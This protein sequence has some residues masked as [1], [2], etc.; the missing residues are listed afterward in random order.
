M[1][2]QPLHKVSVFGA[3]GTIGTAV[4][5]ALLSKGFSV[6]AIARPSSKSTFPSEVLVKKVDLSSKDGLRVA[7]EGQD[8]VVSCVGTETVMVQPILIEAAVQA[9]VK[10]FIPSDFGMDFMKSD[11]KV[12]KELGAKIEILNRLNELSRKYEWFSWSSLVINLLFDW[13]LTTGFLGFD[14]LNNTATIIDSGNQPFSATNVATVGQ[15][16]ASLLSHP[17][18][19]ANKFLSVSSVTT[20]QNEV[21]KLL[22]AESRQK[23]QVEHMSSNDLEKLGDRRKA[24]GD[25]SYFMLYLRHFFFSDGSCGFVKEGD[26]ANWLLGL[27]KEDIRSTIQKDLGLDSDFAVEC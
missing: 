24:E 15:A 22:E 27:E 25:F 21:L 2:S 1:S 12:T 7:L 3:S 6:T 9:K 20:T 11:H 19:T 18:E 16:V 4:V 14:L 10:R 23:W 5:D 8:A 26:S 17:T 13:G